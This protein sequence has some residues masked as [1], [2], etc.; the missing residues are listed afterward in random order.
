MAKIGASVTTVTVGPQGRIVIPRSLRHALSINVGDQL[1]ASVED[2]RL[3]LESHRAVVE[4]LHSLFAHIPPGVSLAS[5]LIA[6]RR[7]E[8]RREEQELNA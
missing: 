4:R 5:E 6:E 1:A 8:A 2:G 7:A 3:V